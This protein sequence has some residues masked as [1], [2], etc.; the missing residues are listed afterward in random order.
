MSTRYQLT[1]QEIADLE[2]AHRHTS[3]KRYADRLK[4]VY[5]LGRGWSVTQV[6]EAL[7]IDRE[8]VRNHY[9][10]DRKGAC[11]R[12]RSSRLAVASLF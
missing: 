12:Y 11:L 2:S 9:K 10:R 3:D 7:M 1:A 4:T 8:T 5:R 6:A